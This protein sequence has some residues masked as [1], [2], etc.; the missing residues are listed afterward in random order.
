VFKDSMGW[1]KKIRVKRPKR[2]ESWTAWRL[3]IVNL[4]RR[5]GVYYEFVHSNVAQFSQRTLVDG[6]HFLP[7]SRLYMWCS[8]DISAGKRS[9]IFESRCG[10]CVLDRST[11]RGRVARIRSESRKRQLQ[12]DSARAWLLFHADFI[13]RLP[14]Q[15]LSTE[16]K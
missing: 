8:W 10:V 16:S 5:Y 7:L 14:F 2:F 3:C 12:M 13:C 9:R 6:V 15:H 11:G 1:M 4:S